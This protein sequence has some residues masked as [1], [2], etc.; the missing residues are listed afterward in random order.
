MFEEC[1][2]CE[3][4]GKDCM[5]NLWLLS[6]EEIREWARN[7]KEYL[8]WSNSDL[9]EASGVP[10]RTIDDKFSKNSSADVRYS[11]FA[12]I[13]CALI[14]CDGK[15]MQCRKNEVCQPSLPYYETMIIRLEEEKIEDRALHKDE[16]VF[17]KDE[18][19]VKT[20]AVITLGFL[21]FALFSLIVFGLITDMLDPNLGFIWR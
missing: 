6:P 1:V 3:R 12:P 8:G 13:I 9:A 14:G 2:N 21:S 19:K 7:R 18:I 16:T 11:T 17:L 20:R 10:K 4:L 15:P 5:P